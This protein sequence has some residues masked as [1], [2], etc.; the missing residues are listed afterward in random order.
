MTIDRRELLQALSAIAGAALAPAALGA[1]PSITTAQ[2]ASLSAA[3]TGFPEPDADTA[4]MVLRA[5]ATPQR[6]ASLA[7]LA[8][9]VSTTPAAQL[10]PAI[11]ADKLDAVANDLVACWYSGVTGSQVVLYAQ[12]LMWSAMSF[13]KPMGVCGGP[14]GYWTDPPSP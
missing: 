10:D 11:A 12:A 1:P 9:V 13:T 6:R 5:F 2:F 8:R 3:L 4:A 14:T 7:A